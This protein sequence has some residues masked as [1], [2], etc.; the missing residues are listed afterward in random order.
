[1]PEDIVYNTQPLR[2]GPPPPSPQ[3][4][5]KTAGGHL[6]SHSIHISCAPGLHKNRIYI[7]ACLD[8]VE[9]PWVACLIP[10]CADKKKGGGPTPGSDEFRAATAR[11]KGQLP[12]ALFHIQKKDIVSQLAWNLNP[13]SSLQRPHSMQGGYCDGRHIKFKASSRLFY[14]L[15]PLY[16]DLR[17]GYLSPESDW[18]SM[19]L[20]LSTT[21]Q[22]PFTG[23]KELDPTAATDIFATFRFPESSSRDCYTLRDGSQFTKTEQRRYSSPTTH[24][25]SLPYHVAPSRLTGPLHTFGTAN[26]SPHMS[27]SVQD[28]SLI[29]PDKASGPYLREKK[30]RRQDGRGRHAEPSEPF[31]HLSVSSSSRR[32]CHGCDAEYPR[33][34]KPASQLIILVDTESASVLANISNNIG[35]YSPRIIPL[36]RLSPAGRGCLP[37]PIRPKRIHTY[38]PSKTAMMRRKVDTWRCEMPHGVKGSH[39]YMRMTIQRRLCKQV[40]PEGTSKSSIE[41]PKIATAHTLF[42]PSPCPLPRAGKENDMQK[43]TNLIA[44]QRYRSRHMVVAWG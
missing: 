43:K 1:L 44:Y 28:K 21:A 5:Q 26:P 33:A 2:P 15:L 22:N 39:V 42:S 19:I 31:M 38:A 23:K 34:S 3:R 17:D 8:P 35:V 9:S 6:R 13:T 18:C 41:S 37:L 20:A 25:S 36:F 29:A 30:K 10:T 12:T 24:T 40:P 4:K 11:G 27:I 7:D 14:P 32:L 16:S